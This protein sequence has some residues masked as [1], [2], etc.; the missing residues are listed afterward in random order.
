M[1]A[2]TIPSL[3]FI[4]FFLAYQSCVELLNAGY[5]LSG[6]YLIKSLPSEVLISVYCDQFS[7]GGG[8]EF[9]SIFSTNQMPD[10]LVARVFPRF[11]QIGCFNF[12]FLLAL[13]DIFLSSDWPS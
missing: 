10:N 8:N 1:F 13:N 3:N 5:N 12:Q 4:I 6:V 9:V 2:C 7:R 11:M